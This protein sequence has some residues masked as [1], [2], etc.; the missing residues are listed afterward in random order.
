VGRAAVHNEELEFSIYPG[1]TGGGKFSTSVY[2]DD[3]A[4]TAYVG[5]AYART[6][7]AYTRTGTSTGT[8]ASVTD[9]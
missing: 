2:E 1:I 9:C 3:G 6:E 4:T 7:C 5:G 8:V